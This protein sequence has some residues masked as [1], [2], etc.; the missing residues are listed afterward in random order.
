M[1]DAGH[2][3]LRHRRKPIGA[4]ALS[5]VPLLKST[6]SLQARVPASAYDDVIAHGNAERGRDQLILHGFVSAFVRA[7]PYTLLSLLNA[8]LPNQ[9]R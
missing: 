2:G 5:C 1:I 4:A 8:A 6:S 3:L 9:A 7:M